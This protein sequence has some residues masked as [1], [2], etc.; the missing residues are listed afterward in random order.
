MRKKK[1]LEAMSLLDD[2]YVAEAAPAKKRPHRRA[3][4]TVAAS[5]ACFALILG[6]FGVY[7]LVGRERNDIE[8]YRDS[9]Y[10]PLMQ[11]LQEFK[12]AQAQDITYSTSSLSLFSRIFGAKKSDNAAPE[13]SSPN[14]GDTL[15]I[16]ATGT[17]SYEEA[18]DNQVE[19]VIEG[20]LIKRSDRYIYYFQKH[21]AVLHVYAI[22]GEATHE[23]GQFA[24]TLPKEEGRL[25]V[26]KGYSWEM[27]LSEDCRTLS[28]IA[29]YYKGLSDGRSRHETAVISLDV[30]DPTAICEKNRVTVAGEYHSS[31]M[32]D[33]KLYLLNRFYVQ[34]PFEWDKEETFVPQIDVGN[35][36]ESLP[37]AQIV[38]PEEITNPA[39]TVICLIDEQTLKLESTLGCL[40]YVD[41]LYA[42][43][44][45][46]YLVRAR[47]EWVEEGNI[48]INRS[49]S[50]IFRVSYTNHSLTPQKTVTVDGQIKDQ[51]SLDEYKGILRVVTSTSPVMQYEQSGKH[52]TVFAGETNAS[53]YAVDIESMQI[54][55]SVE[56]F[57]P[58]GETVRSVRFDGDRGYVCTA[59]RATDPVFFFDLSDIHNITYTDTGTIPGFS[60]SLIQYGD[61]ILLG[62]GEGEN[63]KNKVEIYAEAENR[64]VSLDAFTIAGTTYYATE[65]KSYLI[66]RE[67][68]LFGFVVKEVD[69]P[70]R[71]LI[72]S[73]EGGQLE[74]IESVTL[75]DDHH[76]LADFRCL[77][78][79]GYVYVFADAAFAVRNIASTES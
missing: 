20:D 49:K 50:D 8:N 63:G 3:W 57:A 6:S 58:E 2:E 22:E 16:G 73:L 9:Q 7:R 55:S 62:V 54:I 11:K 14:D 5:A 53:L 26:H 45:A 33:G 74:L 78:I 69:G 65:Y 4:I 13:A 29:P 24:V 44:D 48:T 47:T 27:Y 15:A 40:S 79:D 71:Y 28:M 23:V 76:M 10:Y 61:G 18:T 43:R 35:G 51:Y 39:Y 67:H 59:I 68:W 30:S 46:L 32:V 31:R 77:Y 66:D 64:V 42:S 1:M 19:G 21:N 25:L 12:D 41:D 37:M 56:H 17:Q 38:M 36:F 34:S 70:H 52:A 72:F 75:D 60:T